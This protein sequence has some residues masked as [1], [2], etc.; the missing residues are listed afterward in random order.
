MTRADIQQGLKGGQ[1]L[2]G[3]LVSLLGQFQSYPMR[4]LDAILFPSKGLTGAERARLAASYLVLYGSAGLPFMDMLADKITESTRDESSDKATYKF[5]YNGIIDGFV[6]ATTGENTNFASRGGL[7]DWTYEIIKSLSGSDKSFLEVIAGPAGS[8]G[9]GAVDT[10]VQY[11]KA[12][13]A[14]FNP[15]MNRLGTKAL[16]D[17]AKQV[18]SFNNV[19]R[20][21][22]AW[23]TGKIY[24]SR[25]NQFIELSNV[26]NIL[27][28]FGVP[29]QA[30]QDIGM[31]YGSK[32]K[33]KQIIKLN[34]ELMLELHNE[35][36]RT[37]DSAVIEKINMV[38]AA[39]AQDG[40]SDE[41]NP[42]VVR[43]LKG[44][45]THNRLIQESLGQKQ[46]GEKGAVP[47]EIEVLND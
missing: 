18:S 7:G 12:Y 1:G 44:S 34:T 36:A 32:E 47:L 23:Q 46:V 8:T 35:F 13:K 2:G 22:F 43:A 20:A 15:D 38:A 28:I 25:G 26:G 37:Q 29:P 39:V 19:Y 5:L 27:Q 9:S 41:V 11:A 17:V 16:L 21:W 3:G 45:S 42:A 14:G 30:Y 33:R 10:L 31:I 24:D 6:M 4:A 40:L